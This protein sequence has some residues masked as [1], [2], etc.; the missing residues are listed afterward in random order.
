MPVQEVKGDL[1]AEARLDDPGF[2]LNDDRFSTYAKLRR[3]APVYW[4]ESARCWALSR[5][6][7][8][9]WAELQ[10]NPPLTTGQGLFILEAARPERAE[11]R[12]PTGA[13]RAGTG[14]MSDPPQHTHFRSLVAGAFAPRRLNDLQ[15]AVQAFVDELLDQLPDNEPV[16]FVEALSG[17]LAAGVISAFLGIPREV[18]T[19]VRRWSD[20]FVVTAGGGLS[21]DSPEAQQ[22]AQDQAEMYAY[23][24]ARLTERAQ[25]P[26]EDFLSTVATIELDGKPLPEESQ[27]AAAR[28]LVAG[29]ETTR[30][31][32]SGAMVAFVNHPDQWDKLLADPAL[33]PNATEELLRWVNPV[34]HFGRRVTEPVVIRDQPIAQGDFLVMLYESGNRDEEI[35]QDPHTFDVTRTAPS[36]H[37]SFGWGI[38]R[39]VGAALARLEIRLAL[40]GLAKRFSRWE[41]VGSPEREPST[42]IN[43]YDHLDITLTRRNSV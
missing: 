14:F 9:A 24:T 10:G 28:M 36:P 37:L 42:L 41:L 43:R 1:A 7:D 39:C 29:N 12:D 6:E 3:E 2:Y 15:P 4:C 33:V 31:L 16:D 20:A 18:W 32:L 22:A 26:R 23:L 21:E 38:H 40:E 19:D 8:I 13:Q 35:W 11:A 17:P 25:A 5:H 34:I 27:L 30:N